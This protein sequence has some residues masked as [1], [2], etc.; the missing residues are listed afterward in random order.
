MS[1]STQASYNNKDVLFKVRSIGKNTKNSKKKTQIKKYQ[2]ASRGTINQHILD[3]SMRRNEEINRE[4]P[5]ETVIENVLN[6]DKMQSIALPP[7]LEQEKLKMK[8]L[9]ELRRMQ[10][11]RNK[12]EREELETRKDHNSSSDE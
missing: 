9:R 12:Q 11:E 7:T 1:E 2:R 6:R 5:R 8:K 4:I 10:Q 3:V